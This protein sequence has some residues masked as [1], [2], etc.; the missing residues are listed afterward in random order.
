IQGLLLSDLETLPLFRLSR[1]KVVNRRSQRASDQLRIEGPYSA[2]RAIMAR[3]PG[4]DKC[5]MNIL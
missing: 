4:N 1:L 5:L 3:Q 2:E